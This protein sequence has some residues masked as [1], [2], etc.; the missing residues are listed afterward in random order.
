[1]EQSIEPL[2]GLWIA[3]DPLAQGTTVE[4]TARINHI[5]AKMVGDG[6][7]GR[8]AR[9]D[10]FAGDHIGIHHLDT[11]RGKLIGDSGLAAADT[12]CDSNYIHGG[13]LLKAG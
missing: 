3:E 7:K 11:Q 5:R 1:M 12:T 6:G 4:L 10:H 2:L 13:L 8:G 9:L